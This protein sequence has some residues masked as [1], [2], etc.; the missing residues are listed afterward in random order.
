M[1]LGGAGGGRSAGPSGQVAGPAA[2]DGAILAP[3]NSAP[4][5]R[6][7]VAG[8]WVDQWALAQRLYPEGLVWPNPLHPGAFRASRR[9]A[10]HWVWYRGAQL[11]GSLTALPRSGGWRL[12]LLAQPEATGQVEAA[13]LDRALAG[14]PAEHGSTILDYPAGVAEG[15]LRRA[16]FRP[17]R[18]L[19]WMERDLSSAAL[20]K[21]S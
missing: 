7:R 12:I 19:A 16:G 13:L 20:G 8:E 15:T 10:F 14:L 21:A 6:T 1:R 17:E 2:A 5:V 18:S 9:E 3:G 11:W 4:E